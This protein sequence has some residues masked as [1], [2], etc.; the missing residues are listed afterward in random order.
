[1]LEDHVGEYFRP[2]AFVLE[3]DIGSRFEVSFESRIRGGLKV[4]ELKSVSHTYVV[5]GITWTR[6]KD[7]M[8][9]IHRSTV[10][11]KQELEY[12]SGR[13]NML[14]TSTRIREIS[15]SESFESISV[16]ATMNFENKSVIIN[17]WVYKAPFLYIAPSIWTISIWTNCIGR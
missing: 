9:F 10:S 4:C 2:S 5:I 8:S 6:N 11:L 12:P 16:L 15:R 13:P 7:E 14:K 3:F 17:A 1:M